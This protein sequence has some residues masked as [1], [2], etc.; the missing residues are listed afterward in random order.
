[1][2]TEQ[3]IVVAK[4]SMT[5][6]CRGKST[7]KVR[8]NCTFRPIRMRVEGSG[9]IV[10]MIVRNHILVLANK[11]ASE[12][13]NETPIDCPTIGENA[14]ISFETEGEMEIT[15]SGPSI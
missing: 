6:N 12:F 9:R 4:H 1:M 15:L 8:P 3:E 10:R 14:E 13:V 11:D 2:P 5:F 7:N